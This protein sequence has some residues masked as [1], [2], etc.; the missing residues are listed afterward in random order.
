MKCVIT[1]SFSSRAVVSVPGFDG[2]QTCSIHKENASQVPWCSPALFLPLP[3]ALS[4]S[5][6]HPVSQPC[7]SAQEI[8]GASFI[9]LFYYSVH[10]SFALLHDVYFCTSCSVSLSLFFS[11]MPSLSLETSRPQTS[12]PVFDWQACI[13]QKE[14]HLAVLSPGWHIM[15][16]F[17]LRYLTVVIG[18]S[19]HGMTFANHFTFTMWWNSE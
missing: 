4:L 19:R 14:T 16:E 6:P 1:R 11:L 17:C 3:L 10:C 18:Y 8:W 12:F 2:M 7:Q 13:L 5:I 9:F 15:A